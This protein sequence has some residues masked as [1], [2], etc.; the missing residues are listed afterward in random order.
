MRKE[1]MNEAEYGEKYR[2]RDWSRYAKETTEKFVFGPRGAGQYY[3]SEEY[4]AYY[5]KLENRDIGHNLSEGHRKGSLS[6]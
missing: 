3:K 1:A 4:R 5:M 2:Y 6:R